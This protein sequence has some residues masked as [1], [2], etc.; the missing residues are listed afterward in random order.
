MISSWQQVSLEQYVEIIDVVGSLNKED[1]VDDTITLI[2]ILLDKAESEIAEMPYSKFIELEDKISFISEPIPQENKEELVIEGTAFRLIP[3]NQL[4]FG[5]FIDIEALLTQIKGS[6]LHNLAKIFTILYRKINKKETLFNKIEYES[7]G[8]WTD[9]R[10]KYFNTL[11]ITDIYGV[12][13]KYMAFRAKLFSSYEGLFAEKET[14]EDEEDY[15]GLSSKEI[16]AIEQEKRV[17]KWG[18]ELLL[19]RLAA[20]DPLKMGDAT[21]LPIIQALNILSMQ[22]ELKMR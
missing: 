20:N 22:Q 7:Y 13:I 10:E 19:L 6:Y 5:A 2:S 17:G 18:W 1:Y 15:T 12:I 3:F 4:E 11:P 16:E 14:E 21:D 8:N 9:I